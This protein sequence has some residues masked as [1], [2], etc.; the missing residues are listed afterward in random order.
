MKPISAPR[1]RG[2]AAIVL[3][4]SAAALNRMAYTAALFWKAISAADGG[5]VKTTW[6]YGDRQQFGLPLGQPCRSRGPL[7]FRAMAV[8]A[9]IIGDADQAAVGTTL[10]MA[11]EPRCPARLDRAHDA[12][13]SSAK[14]TGTRLTIRLAVTAEDVRHLQS[15]H[16][17][18]GSGRRDALAA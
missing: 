7:A 4:A 6:K 11:A 8:A 14:M 17:R 13:L 10:D 15:G 18:F 9:G 2:S 3:S 12:A 5:S 1:W 16:G